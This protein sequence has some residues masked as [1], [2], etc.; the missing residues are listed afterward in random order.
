[1]QWDVER[2]L[3]NKEPGLSSLG[4]FFRAFCLECAVV[5]SPINEAACERE[6]RARDL[7]TDGFVPVAVQR[8]NWPPKPPRKK[9]T[10]KLGHLELA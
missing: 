1:M 7:V 9:R 3:R 10:D 8:R 2:F 5:P 4:E 6:L